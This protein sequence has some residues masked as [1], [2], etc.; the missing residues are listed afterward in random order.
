MNGPGPVCCKC[1][2][3]MTCSKTGR[4]V[5]IEASGRPYQ[6][7]SGDEF[8]CKD[9]GATAVVQYAREPVSENYKE[10]FA[11]WWEAWLRN[12]AVLVQVR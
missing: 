3:I 4:G 7:W 1:Q 2:K 6:V 11:D 8:A 10:G 5:L 9:C 12:G